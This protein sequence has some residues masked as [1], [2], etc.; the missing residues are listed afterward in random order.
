MKILKSIITSFLTLIL[1][2]LISVL[3]ISI[4][5]KDLLIEDILYEG[6]KSTIINKD[7]K[8]RNTTLDDIITE[9]G[10]I[11]D[12]DFVNEILESPEIKELVNKYLDKII[13]TIA[14]ENISVDELNEFNLEQDM[15]NYIKDNKEVLSEKTGIEITDEMIEEASEKLEEIDTKKIVKQTVVNVRNNLS[16]QEKQLLK[17]YNFIT[18]S[19]LKIYLI[20]GIVI[21]LLLIAIIKKSLY[22]WIRNLSNAMTLAGIGT[23]IMSKGLEIIIS[24]MLQV[25]ETIKLESMSTLSMK[26][27]ICGVIVYIIYKLISI[28]IVKENKNEVSKVSE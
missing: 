22:K 24:K 6:F 19:A 8:E 28:F 12:N 13:T 17:A 7:Y 9:E 25:Q 3:I 21:I 27:L 1:T 5:F 10:V 23:L 26:V 14:D 11:T 16:P 20:I 18:S 2:I 15:I 4:T